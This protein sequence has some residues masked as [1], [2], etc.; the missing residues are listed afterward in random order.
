M[1]LF[2]S[3][4]EMAQ[5]FPGMPALA[6][7][8]G[9]KRSEVGGIRAEVVS[10]AKIPSSLNDVTARIGVRSLAQVI[11]QREPAPTLAVLKLKRAPAEGSRNSGGYQWSSRGD[12]PFPPTPGDRLDVEITTR[13]VAPI[14]LMLPALRRFFGW[15]PLQPQRAPRFTIATSA[16]SAIAIRVLSLV[17]Y[18]S[19][20]SG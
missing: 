18:S 10:M 8:S 20:K 3:S 12:L 2:L 6:T 16:H 17:R 15:T 11:I 9:Y 7:P 14:E 5:V 13:K 1:P 19:E 4:K